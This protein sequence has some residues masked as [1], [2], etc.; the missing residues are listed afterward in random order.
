MLFKQLVEDYLQKSPP[1]TE[2]QSVIYGKL[3]SIYDSINLSSEVQKDPDFMSLMFSGKAKDST[4]VIKALEQL[5]EMQNG[6]KKPKKVE[7][8]YANSE[9]EVSAKKAADKKA[10]LV[11]FKV[12]LSYDIYL[13]NGK[14][15]IEMIFVLK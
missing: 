14:K 4:A 12:G 15:I 2:G 6:A 9:A 3:L 10:T 7:I 1:T 8:K 5:S 13:L 11:E